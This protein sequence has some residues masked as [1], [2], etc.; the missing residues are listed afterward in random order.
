MAKSKEFQD[1]SNSDN[2]KKLIKYYVKT[3]DLY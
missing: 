1:N 3:Y 2:V